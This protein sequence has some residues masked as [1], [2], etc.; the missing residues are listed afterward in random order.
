MYSGVFRRKI[1]L[2]EGLLYY[3]ENL[4]SAPVGKRIV[5]YRQRANLTMEDLAKQTGLEIDFLKAV[6]ESDLYPSLGPLIKIARS[7]GVRLGTFLDDHVSEDP[8]IVRLD[9]RQRQLTTHRG[10]QAP[11]EVAFYPLGLGKSDRRMEPF[12]VELMP[13]SGR[14]KALSSHEGEEFIVV[15]SG[16]VEL[17]Y[18]HET[19]ILNPGDSI[20][21]NSVVPHHLGCIGDEKASIYAVLFI[22]E[23]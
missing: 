7:L 4:M 21:Y 22:M 2:A 12:F 18:G 15:V 23:L 3:R 9:E 8:L 11:A 16:Q 14:N 13:A 17:I 20:Y 6:E 5:D 19:H 1:P 10:E